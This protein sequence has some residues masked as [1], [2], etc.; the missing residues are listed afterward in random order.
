MPLLGR[1]RFCFPLPWL[2]AFSVFFLIP[3]GTGFLTKYNVKM[4]RVLLCQ[5]GGIYL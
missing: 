2:K 4:Q 1:D 3:S 5:L